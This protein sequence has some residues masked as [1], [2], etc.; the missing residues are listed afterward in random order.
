MSIYSKKGDY[1]QTSLLDTKQVSKSDDRINLVG[2]IDELTSHLGI[3]KASHPKR[4]IRERITRI[5]QD[6][7]LIMASVADQYNRQYKLSEEKVSQLEVEIDHMQTL[8]PKITKFILPG[9]N[10]LSAQIDVARTVARRAERVMA[11]VAKKHNIDG[12][13]RKFINRLSDYL[14]VV[15]RYTDFLL[16]GGTM[17]GSK[18]LD[19]TNSQ[20]TKEADDKGEQGMQASDKTSKDDIINEVINRIGVNKNK[21]C[22]S[23]AKKLIERVEEYARSKGLNAVIAVCNPQ[24]NPVA[25]HV[26]DDAFIA[27][28]D[29]ALNKA[30]TSVAVKMS[31]E[32]LAKLAVPGETFY[33]IDK[34][35]D[36]KIIIIGGGVPLE[37]DG[38]IIGGLGVSGG[39][40]KEDSDIANYG[41][42]IIKEVLE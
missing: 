10:T 1:G 15:A 7:Y 12:N 25:V 38:Q 19:T 29:I 18:A 31:T 5:Q 11:L 4:E 2:T 16:S 30:Y 22:L 8:Y 42:S 3:V 27:S 36:G 23:S 20:L 14:F 13:A 40:A 37:V 41:L 32:K 35:N 6:L 28:F 26:M 21:I 24:G 9:D 33:G 39:T 17:E 34:S